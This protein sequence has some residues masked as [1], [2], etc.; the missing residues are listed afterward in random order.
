VEH[1]DGSSWS[2]APAEPFTNGYLNEVAAVSAKDV[3]AVGGSYSGSSLIEH[4]DGSVWSIVSSPKTGAQFEGVAAR[5]ARCVWAVGAYAGRRY[6]HTL[7]ERWDGGGWSVVASPQGP[8]PSSDLL[9]VTTIPSTRDL[10]SVGI[11]S[12]NSTSAT[13]IEMFS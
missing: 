3:W 7:T 8:L 1:W 12:S 2:I 10:W 6:D 9:A 4:W 13:L 11:T 5:N